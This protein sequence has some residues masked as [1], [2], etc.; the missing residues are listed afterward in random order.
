MAIKRGVDFYV[1]GYTT[2]SIGFPEGKIACQWCHLF[3]QYDRDFRRYRCAL[4]YEWIIDPFHGIGR[5]CPLEIE[6]SKNQNINSKGD[7]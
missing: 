4:T 2:V 3:L 6:D 7:E 1:K 5:C